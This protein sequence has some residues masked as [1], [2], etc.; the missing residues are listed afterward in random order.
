V[1]LAPVDGTSQA[2]GQ[3]GQRAAAAQQLRALPAVAAPRLQRSELKRALRQREAEL[4]RRLQMMRAQ[5]AGTE[6]GT[7]SSGAQDESHGVQLR[8]TELRRG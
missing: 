7:G 1:I 3:D 2:K 4:R 5:A 6:D 8:V